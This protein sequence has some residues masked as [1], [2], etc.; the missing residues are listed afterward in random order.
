MK[1]PA[2]LIFD[3]ATS[4]LD[5]ETE[6]EIQKALATVSKGCTTVIIAHRLST[7]IDA[8]EILVFDKGEIIEQGCHQDLL[9]LNKTYSQ[10][11]EKQQEAKEAAEKLDK[12]QV[13]S[14]LVN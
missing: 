13:N 9:G 8:D 14:L 4:A 5:T 12:K 10:M 2:I 6:K 3:E 7:I 11:W 1:S